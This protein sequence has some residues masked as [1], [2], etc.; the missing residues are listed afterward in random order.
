MLKLRHILPILLIYLASCDKENGLFDAI[1]TDAETETT[2]TAQEGFRWVLKKDLETRENFRRNFGLGYSY[3]AVSGEYCN[4]RDIRC[5]VLNRY[6]V[7]DL[8]RA[9][10][11]QLLNVNT[12]RTLTHK[13]QFEYSL[14]DYVANVGIETDEENKDII[15]WKKNLD[16]ET[17]KETT[18]QMGSLKTL[19]SFSE[20]L[21][22][23]LS[24]KNPNNSKVLL[25]NT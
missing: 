5:Q 10:A 12:A 1:E 2:V 20:M 24:K 22:E 18:S 8:Q 19:K 23:G 9:S 15:Y 6:F 7:E 17:I 21:L 13:S 25:T 4:W 16:N 3:D 11:E 14:R